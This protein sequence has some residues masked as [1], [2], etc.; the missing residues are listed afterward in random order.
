MYS[1]VLLVV[2]E[3]VVHGASAVK[4]VAVLGRV[5]LHLDGHAPQLVEE[6]LRRQR[7]KQKLLL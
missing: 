1:P 2:L 7:A 3:V 4:E 5:L 6:A